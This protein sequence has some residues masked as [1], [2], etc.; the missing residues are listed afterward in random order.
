[1]GRADV[2]VRSTTTVGRKEPI[3]LDAKTEDREIIR[4]M[5]TPPPK[6]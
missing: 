1:M 4:A 2:R 6:S 5:I 3:R